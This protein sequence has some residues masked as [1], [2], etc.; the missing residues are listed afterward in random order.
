MKN[1]TPNILLVISA[2]IFG[3]SFF[4]PSFRCDNPM[5]GW[6]CARICF[7]ILFEDKSEGILWLAYYVAF[8]ASNLFMAIVPVLVLF[9]RPRTYPIWLRVIQALLFIHVLSW[10]IVAPIKW[11]DGNIMMGY[12]VWVLSMLGALIGVH[13]KKSLEKIP[14]GKDDDC[15]EKIPTVKGQAC[16]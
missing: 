6:E 16:S 15:N 7:V 11:P 4:L 14:S 9:K 10:I 3:I 2:V 13:T 12:Y 1:R 8:N 5:P